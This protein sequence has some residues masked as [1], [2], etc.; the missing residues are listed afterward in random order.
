MFI[1]ATPEARKDAAILESHHLASLGW[2]FSTLNTS[3]LLRDELISFIFCS[4]DDWKHFF[5]VEALCMWTWCFVYE[6]TEIA[7]STYLWVLYH[8]A[9]LWG[10]TLMRHFNKIK[11][12]QMDK[13]L[14]SSTLMIMHHLWRKGKRQFFIISENK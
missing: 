2:E 1:Q 6:L 7:H 12:T 10:F 11:A 5:Y 9:I 4:K 3:A 13:S 8:L 14:E